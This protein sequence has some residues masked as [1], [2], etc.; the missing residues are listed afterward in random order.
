MDS[1][2]FLCNL[3]NLTFKQALASCKDFRSYLQWVLDDASETDEQFP[4]TL[5]LSDLLQ[6]LFLSL[7]L[8]LSFELENGIN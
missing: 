3:L 2:I 7:F 4:L 6:G 5:A 8:S 1:S